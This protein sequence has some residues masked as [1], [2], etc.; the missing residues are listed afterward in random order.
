MRMGL[1]RGGK[2]K[3]RARMGTNRT[4]DFVLLCGLAD[5]GHVGRSRVLGEHTYANV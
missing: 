3:G 5:S 2:V 4:S 1:G